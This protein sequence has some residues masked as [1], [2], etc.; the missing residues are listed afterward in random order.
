MESVVKSAQMIYPDKRSRPRCSLRHFL[1]LVFVLCLLC[2]HSPSP[3]I[4][5]PVLSTT[6]WTGSVL[7]TRGFGAGSIPA[8]GVTGSRNPAPEHPIP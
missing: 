1:R 4:F 5:R 8:L 7:L 2:C 6:R 3:K